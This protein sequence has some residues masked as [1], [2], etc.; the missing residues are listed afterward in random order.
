MLSMVQ[1]PAEVEQAVRWAKFCP[2]GERGVNGGN[3]D[4]RFGLVPLAEY[5]ARANAE[6]FIGIQIETAGALESVA[7]IAAIPD[8][9]LIFVGPSDLSQVLGVHGRL[10]EPPLPRGDPVDRQGIGRGRQALGRLLPRP[11]LRRADAGVGLPALRRRR[12]HPRRARRHPR[13]QGAI[14]L[15][16]P[17]SR[18]SLVG[19]LKPTD[20]RGGRRWVSHP[21]RRRP[22][23]NRRSGAESSSTP[24]GAAIASLPAGPA[25]RRAR[26]VHHAP[27]GSGRTPEVVSR[28]PQAPP[29]RGGSMHPL[30]TMVMALNSSC[31]P[32]SAARE[33]EVSVHRLEERGGH[34]AIG[35]AAAA[36][37]RS[38]CTNCGAVAY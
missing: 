37:T 8:V 10:R 6:T 19:W 20:G 3:R 28:I 36:C 12:R 13:R 9:D 31:G 7:E 33:Q 32:F 27:A 21:T 25:S 2:R 14:R 11:G 24:R 38:Q 1:S 34:L 4:G 30:A 22:T 35:R 5:T 29:R 16:L 17:A 18:V 26:A 15:V 23:L